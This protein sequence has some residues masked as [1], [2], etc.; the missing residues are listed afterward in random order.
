MFGTVLFNYGDFKES[1]LFY[2]E[3]RVNG[4]SCY[5]RLSGIKCGEMCPEISTPT[6]IDVTGYTRGWDRSIN[7]NDYKAHLWAALRG[8]VDRCQY[9]MQKWDERLI[10]W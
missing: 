8:T 10:L 9:F 4:E 5:L 7:V 2:G 6:S 1:A 3:I